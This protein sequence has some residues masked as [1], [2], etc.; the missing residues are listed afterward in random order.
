MQRQPFWFFFNCWLYYQCFFKGQFCDEP[1]STFVPDTILK[2]CSK[3][4]AFITQMHRCCVFFS[5]AALLEMVCNFYKI[6]T[7]WLKLCVL[8][9][10]NSY[11]ATEPSH[12]RF[13]RLTNHGR[14]REQNARMKVLDFNRVPT[15]CLFSVKRSKSMK[16][17]C[18][19]ME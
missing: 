18:M 4:C 14:G 11:D 16:K 7:F 8:S 5:Y 10:C 15:L 12:L 1:I 3:L 19:I 13:G 9:Y 2:I 17:S 6:L